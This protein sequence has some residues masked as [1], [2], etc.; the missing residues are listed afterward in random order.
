MIA[1]AARA[2]RAVSAQIQLQR[3]RIVTLS[4]LLLSQERDVATLALGFAFPMPGEGPRAWGFEAGWRASGAGW[5]ASVAGWRAS[6]AGWLASVAGW[7]ASVAGCP[8]SVAGWLAMV[9]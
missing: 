8:A 2:P 6:V 3:G 5:R 4:L 1:Y 7:L 9:A